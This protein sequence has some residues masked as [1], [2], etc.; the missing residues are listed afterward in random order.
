VLYVVSVFGP[1]G[2][3][4]LVRYYDRKK[5]V[6]GCLAGARLLLFLTRV[7]LRKIIRFLCEIE[8]IKFECN[9]FVLVLFK[10]TSNTF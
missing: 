5:K 3:K 4:V 6:L 8:C 1:G 10:N 7:R 2:K 9:E